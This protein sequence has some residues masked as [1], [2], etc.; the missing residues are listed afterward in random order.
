M[1]LKR[2]Q[3]HELRVGMF[4]ESIEGASLNVPFAGRRFVLESLEIAEA[5]QHSNLSGIFINTAKGL[6]VAPTTGKGL[7]LARNSVSGNSDFVL[8]RSKDRKA[9][10]IVSRSVTKTT[11]LLKDIFGNAEKDGVSLEA[12]SPIVTQISKVMDLNPSLLIQFTRLKSKDETTYFHSIA[13]SAF[14]I[15]FARVLRMDEETIHHLGISG[16]LHD[17]GKMAIPMELLTK[18][19][20]LT[21]AEMEQMRTHP[22]RG[23]EILSKQAGMPDIVL[24]VCLHHHE[25]LDGKGYPNGLFE[26]QISLHARMA[27][28]CDVYDAVTSARPY[29]RPWTSEEAATWMVERI[30]YF[31]RELLLKFLNGVTRN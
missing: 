18:A 30:G 27:A 1:M 24:D 7:D 25:R 21:D 23:H 17:I 29:K 9:L 8:R 19:G 26:G 31:D 13:V 28:I 16:L 22:R 3:G 14:M 6:D 20:A 10:A 11:N 12:I 4:V 15:R 5:L 2:I